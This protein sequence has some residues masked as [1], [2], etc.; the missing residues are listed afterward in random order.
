[1][2]NNKILFNEKVKKEKK[3]ENVVDRHHFIKQRLSKKI[4]AL[5]ILTIICLA[6]LLTL[7]T[8]WIAPKGQSF[9]KTNNKDIVLKAFDKET[10][11]TKL[12]NKEKLPSL[13]KT[14]FGQIDDVKILKDGKYLVYTEEEQEK[15]FYNI[16]FE[17]L[18]KKEANYKFQFKGWLFVNR[19][20][21][22]KIDYS[23]YISI[24]TKEN[25]ENKVMFFTDKKEEI[26]NYFLSNLEENKKYDW[27]LVKDNKNE[28][29]AN[30][31]DENKVD[32]STKE[33]VENFDFSNNLLAVLK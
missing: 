29:E 26:G 25:N 1:M 18:Y 19:E 5:L 11:L 3:V 24:F 9:V 2:A 30:I 12:T 6:L 17:K 15:D 33:A 4:S 20:K 13:F 32:L 7:F 16:D 31:V 27:Y 21:K 23:S 14:V 28:I 8:G 22:L 10:T